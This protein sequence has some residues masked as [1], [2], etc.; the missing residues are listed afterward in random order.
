MKLVDIGLIW[1]LFLVVEAW[2]KTKAFA[3]GMRK[4]RNEPRLLEYFEYLYNEIKKR[5]QQVAKIQ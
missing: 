1:R 2:E 5:E 3:E 4:Q